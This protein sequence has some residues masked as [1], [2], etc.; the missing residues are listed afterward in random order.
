MWFAL[1]A[2]SRPDSRRA[3]EALTQIMTTTQLRDGQARVSEWEIAEFL[4][5]TEHVVKNILRAIFD[6][7]GCW[8]RVELALRFVCE[9]ES[10]VYDQVGLEMR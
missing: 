4:G 3:L 9:S 5:T 1:A 8:N 6:R 2:N 10:S 7:A